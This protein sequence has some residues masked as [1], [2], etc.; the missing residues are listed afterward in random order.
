MSSS[1]HDARAIAVVDLGFGDAG[2]GLVVDFLVRTLHAQLVVRFNGGA[3]A[4]HNVVADGR[5]HTF[6]QLGAGTFVPGVRTHLSRH[7]VVHPTAAILEANRLKKLGVRDALDRLT[8]SPDA[9]VVT[10]F[11]QAI[12]RLREITRGGARHGSCGV[13]VGETVRDSLEATADAL[14][15][16]HL[17]DEK[18]AR[19][20]LSRARDRL[21]A[22]F[23][24]S[25]NDPRAAIEREILDD[26]EIADI[27]LETAI[28]FSKRVE[29]RDDESAMRLAGGPVIL[30]GA[31]GVL[32]DERYGFHPFTTWSNCTFDNASELSS[33]LGADL[34]RLGVV[35]TFAHRHGPGPLPTETDDLT[36]LASESHNRDDLWQGKFRTGWQDLVL[37]RYARRVVGALD[38]IALTHL[39]VLEAASRWNVCTHYVGADGAANEDL[40]PGRDLD[41]Q[42]TVTRNLLEA[43][44]RYDAIEGTILER[45]EACVEAYSR[46]FSAPIAIESRGPTAA[47]CSQ[48]PR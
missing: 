46:A 2:K 45:T 24:K 41:A 18:S 13:G 43:S 11:H 34:F 7:V 42:T 31:Q 8:V 27:W 10:P 30:E 4:G 25:T 3:Q 40:E 6:S 38:A 23:D 20:L 39:D 29:L 17:R 12:G 19:S 16:F 33:A 5:H 35:R 15:T 26:P 22:S 44:P 14:R 47:D 1:F 28:L 37:A 9:L 21:A 48:L 36:K 32:L